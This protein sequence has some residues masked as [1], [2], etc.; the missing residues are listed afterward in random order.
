FPGDDVRDRRF[1]DARWTVK[2]TMIQRFPPL[3]RGIHADA[4]RVLHPRLAHVFVQGL[5]PERNLEASL[6]IAWLCRHHTVRHDLAPSSDSFGQFL[7]RFPDEILQAGL[8]VA[9]QDLVDEVLDVCG[10]VA[11]V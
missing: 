10:P 9:R 7:Q 11:E 5:R 1:A 6:L 4:K 3:L 2:D 8:A